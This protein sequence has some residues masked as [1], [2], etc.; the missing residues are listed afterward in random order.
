M[1]LIGLL[2]VLTGLLLGS[3]A[4][5]A[6]AAPAHGRAA[7]VSAA[8]FETQVL[9]RINDR[10]KSAGCGALKMQSALRNAARKH[11]ARM[12]KKR[13]LSHQLPGEGKLRKRV[14]KA[15]YKG[16]N[17]LAENIAFGQKSAKAIEKMWFKSNGHRKNMLNCV[18]RDAGIGVTF[19]GSEAWVTLDL[20]RR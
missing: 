15:G 11:T 14:E 4:V 16:W 20:G 12:V 3:A 8:D 9:D 5:P 13:S 10:R 18:Y 6:T 19:S 7:A 1:P 17:A 2:V